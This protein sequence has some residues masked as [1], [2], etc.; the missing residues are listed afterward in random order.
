MKSGFVPASSLIS[1]TEVQMGVSLM[2]KAQIA[3]IIILTLLT[4]CNTVSGDPNVIGIVVDKDTE[5]KILVINGISQ[6]ELDDNLKEII[7]SGKYK[8]AYWIEYTGTKQVEIG[9]QVKVWF[10]ADIADSYPA[11]TSSGKIE[12]IQ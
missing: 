2:K 10:S 1:L 3:F 8:E 6:S 12:I 4:S 11:E 5:G 9:D 7:N